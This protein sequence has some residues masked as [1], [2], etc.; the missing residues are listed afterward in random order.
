MNWTM[1][2]RIVEIASYKSRANKRRITLQ[3]SAW[4]QLALIVFLPFVAVRL[5]EKISANFFPQEATFENYDIFRA[6]CRYVQ[7]GDT[8]VADRIESV[9]IEKAGDGKSYFI[10]SRAKSQIGFLKEEW[11][12][13][14]GFNSPDPDGIRD[15]MTPELSHQAAMAT[16]LNRIS[17]GG[18]TVLLAIPKK[19]LIRDHYNRLL[20]YLYAPDQ[21]GA[22]WFSMTQF[23][24]RSGVGDCRY[25][26]PDNHLPVNLIISSQKQL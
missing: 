7:D 14:L 4:L 18:K 20:A 25:G 9:Q 12:R 11:V 10:R 26:V 22:R 17:V 13:Y 2:D 19:G 16:E 23:L 1:Q 15:P 5:V 21:N 3:N 8:I 24:L 6:H